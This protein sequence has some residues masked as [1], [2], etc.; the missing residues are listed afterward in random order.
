M[1]MSMQCTFVPQFLSSSLAV[2]GDVINFDDVS[3]L[4]EQFTP[5]TFSS[6]LLKE[7]SQQSIE[8]GMGSES[9]A[10]IQQI[11]VVGASCS[12]DLDMT[13][14]LGLVML[15]EKRS[16][17]GEAPPFPLI[18][19]PVVV[20]N[21][22]HAFVRMSA[23]G[24]ALK[25]LKEDVSAVMEGFCG[26]HTAIII[27]PFEYHL[28]QFFDELSLW[29]MDVLSDEELQFLEMSLDRLFT[30]GD[31]GFEAECVIIPIQRIHFYDAVWQ[32]AAHAVIIFVLT[33]AQT[34]EKPV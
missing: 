12:F 14:D 31:D 7:L 29:G 33:A 28:V 27:R 2:R 19:M 16:P 15:P 5:A 11:P 20:R 34:E 21:P 9:F 26:H 18:D 8:H 13:L 3:V 17:I 25:L 6:L 32:Y 23:F 30:W 4:K 10:P 22:D 24:P 1:A